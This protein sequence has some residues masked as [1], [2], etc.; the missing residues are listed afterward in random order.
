MGTGPVASVNLPRDNGSGVSASD[1]A[2][3]V[4]G[5][6]AFAFALY[7]QLA[8]DPANAGQNVW[9]SPL[10]VSMALAMASAGAVGQTQ[11]EMAQALDFTLPQSNLQAAFNWLDLSLAQRPAMAGGATLSL[12]NALWGQQT[13]AWQTPFLGVLAT[14]YGTGIHLGD[15]LNS[16]DS[17]RSDVNDWVSQQTAQRIQNVLPP[18]SVSNKTRLLIVNAIDLAFPWQSPFDPNHSGLAPFTPDAGQALSVNTMNQVGYWTY[19]EDTLAQAVWLPLAGGQLT[20]E[21]YLPKAGGVASLEP[22]LA[23]E[24][25]SLRAAR[26]STWVGVDLPSFTY[27]TP[28]VPLSSALEALGMK[29]AFTLGADFSG[30]TTTQPLHLDEV[31]HEAMLSLNETG[32]QAAAATASTFGACGEIG[33]TVVIDVDHSFLVGIRDEVTGSLL[34]LGRI[35]NPNAQGA[36]TPVPHGSPC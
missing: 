29:T 9:C 20:V 1:Q 15:F 18:G 34:F 4:S 5:N 22:V 24:V 10:S 32:V 6:N 30:M 21:I 13:F 16:P 26:A 33:P 35:V 8:G 2:A 19:A 3:L 12:A 23:S 25:A 36:V 11:T 28:P 7:G 17:V 31:Y 14:D 27:T